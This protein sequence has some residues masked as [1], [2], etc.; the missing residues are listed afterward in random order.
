MSTTTSACLQCGTMAKSGEMTCCG[1]GGSWFKNCGSAGNTRL[2]HTWYEGIQTCKAQTRAKT[3]VAQ[4]ANSV[5]QK[6]IGFSHSD[7][8]A[9]STGVDTAGISLA[10]NVPTVYAIRT[11]KSKVIIGGLIGITSLPEMSAPAPSIAPGNKA[12]EY[13]LNIGL[14]INL[15]IIVVFQC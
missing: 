5:L 2:R 14:H 11:I 10:S 15:L 12:R 3:V 9:N 7:D 1:R 6:G 4:Q 13:L 8:K